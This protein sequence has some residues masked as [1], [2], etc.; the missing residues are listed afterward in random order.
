MAVCGAAWV[1]IPRGY[2]PNHRM[3]GCDPGHAGYSRVSWT[4]R[5]SFRLRSG[6]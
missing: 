3:R 4:M 5:C 2:R 6:G 1:W